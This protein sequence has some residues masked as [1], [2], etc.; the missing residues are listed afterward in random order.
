MARP[1]RTVEPGS[2][3]RRTHG[4]TRSHSKASH[5][6]EQP[7]GIALEARNEVADGTDQPH[8]TVNSSFGEL[9]AM[10]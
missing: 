7:N 3:V 8:R 6:K 5:D 2:L 10:H 4:S 1:I 9:N